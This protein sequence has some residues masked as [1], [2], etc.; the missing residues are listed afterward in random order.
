MTEGV[1]DALER[2][3]ESE[4]LVQQGF[5]LVHNYTLKGSYNVS[6]ATINSKI[7]ALGQELAVLSDVEQTHFMR[8]ITM[9]RVDIL[10]PDDVKKLRRIDRLIHN[11]E[12]SLPDK[13]VVG[14]LKF[15][16]NTGNTEFSVPD[17]VGIFRGLN[18]KTKPLY[19][20][21]SQMAGK[22]KDKLIESVEVGSEDVTYYKLTDFG[23]G[24]A[25]SLLDD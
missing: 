21:I 23:I 11:T 13:V 4:L 2:W 25:N 22:A 5:L 7:L 16:I 3:K 14:V 17:M 19:T 18:Q 10:T 9:A 1:C 20:G 6:D 8:Y 12:L 24:Y 15:Q